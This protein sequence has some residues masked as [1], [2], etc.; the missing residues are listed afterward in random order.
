MRIIVDKNVMIPMRDGV[1]LAADLYRIDGAEPSPALVVRLPYNKEVPG[2]FANVDVFRF[3]QAGYA[4]LVQDVR[5]TGASEGVLNP[6]FQ[7][8]QDG[9]DTI[10]WVEKQPWCNGIVGMTGSSYYGATQWYAAQERP[11]ALRAMAADVTWED[12]Y[13]GVKYKNGAYQLGSALTW[14]LLM[15]QGEIM[16]NI[17]RGHPVPASLEPMLAG[18]GDPAELFRRLPL[19]DVPLFR[20]FLSSYYDWLDHSSYDR[21]WSAT[22]AREHYDKVDVP[23]LHTGGWYDIFLNGTLRN[24]IGMRQRGA[25]AEARKR[26]KLIIGPWSHRNKTGSFPEAEFGI[27]A[28][29]Q[30]L[31]LSGIQLRWFDRWLKGIDNGIDREKPVTI[32]VM[33][34]NQW[35]HEDDW[36]LPDTRYVPYYLHSEGHANTAQGDGKLK[37]EKPEGEQFADVYLYNPLNPVPT[38][39]GG[40]LIPGGNSDGPR[41][42]RV[43]EMRDDV[44]C[45]TTGPLERDL[46]VTGHVRL[47]LYV[48]SSAPDTDFTAKLIDVHPDGR[49]MLLTDGI[50]RARYRNS[51]SRPELME[52]GSIYELRI[53]LAATS[54]VFRAGHRIRLEVSSS[55]FPRF[56]RNS[57]TGGDI[58]RERLEEYVPAVNRV[59]HDSDHPS[60]LMLPVIER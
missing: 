12:A 1:K 54:N 5:G 53:D 23:V 26:Q 28:S 57:N 43:V 59:H 10:A 42:Q 31:D 36:P 13:N 37:T 14:S 55:N 6:F 44:L 34:I 8:P 27:R 7:E 56:A 60:H 9:A 11:P 16:R 49:A 33:G 38:V 4:V 52:P 41:D 18:A 15:A 24:Y 30:F 48:S 40:T 21:Y 32:F 3:V 51:L 47:V 25:S 39:G 46:E 2:Y 19:R 29:A 58:A 22:A 45:Y 17:K 35:R 50:M 20:D